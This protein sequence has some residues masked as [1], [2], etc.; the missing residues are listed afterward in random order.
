MPVSAVG[1]PE[2]LQVL[3]PIWTE[4]HE[5]AKRLA[6]RIKAVL[7]VAKS[8]GY[9][10]GENP[11]TTI[12]DARVLPQVKHKVQH[13]KSMHWKDV[14]AFH[15]KLVTK[16]A[17]AAKA[18]MFTCL[19]ASRTSEV[20]NAKWEEFDF[21]ELLWTVPAER[22]K[23]D[24][25]HRIPLTPQMVAILGPLRALRSE[26]V[27]EGQ[28][29]HRP[30]SNMAMLMLLRRMEVNGITV[31]GFRSTFRDWASEQPNISRELAEM[32]LSHKVGSDVERAY[33]RSDLLDKRRQL[34]STWSAFVCGEE[35]D[36]GHA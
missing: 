21:N 33:A 10:D 3:L 15:A 23:T 9:R 29:R 32:S 18:L 19:T 11:L 4:K 12:R 13:H 31:H 24:K 26:V 28:R 8:R 25:A 5:T 27:F 14:P 34:L 16:D 22:M 30:M 7:D 2:I 35:V 1:Q 36:A 17:M 20:L 6:Q